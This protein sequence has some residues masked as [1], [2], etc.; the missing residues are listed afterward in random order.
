MKKR[1]PDSG[2]RRVVTH[3]VTEV[4]IKE[5]LT[6]KAQIQRDLMKRAQAKSGLRM[7][8][9]SGV[10]LKA[11]K[12]EGQKREHGIYLGDSGKGCI[13]VLLDEQYRTSKKDDGLRE[14]DIGQIE[15]KS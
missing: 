4:E 1:T 13:I 11:N 5:N 9:N 7:A 15:V 2:T 12:R 6:N 14:V 8:A 10:W 3:R